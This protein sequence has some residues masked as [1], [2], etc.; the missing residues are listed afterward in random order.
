MLKRGVIMLYNNASLY[1]AY[2]VQDTLCSL[3]LIIT[4]GA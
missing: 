1:V 4:H 2:T 3:C